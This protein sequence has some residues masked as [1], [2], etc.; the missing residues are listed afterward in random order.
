MWHQE[1]QVRKKYSK[2][3]NIKVT[4]FDS[5][6]DFAKNEKIDLT[7]IGMDDPAVGRIVDRFE[8]KRGLGVF[9]IRKDAA[10]LEGS[11]SIL[12]KSL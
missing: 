10:I 2:Y 4:D 11:E 5:L 1:M 7:V 8:K 6:V 12:L 3:R 9:R